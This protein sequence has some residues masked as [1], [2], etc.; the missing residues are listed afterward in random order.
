MGGRG[1]QVRG[2]F[3]LMIIFIMFLF[4]VFVF[5]PVQGQTGQT[6]VLCSHQLELICFP[7]T[8]SKLLS[9]WS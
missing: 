4:R 8:K 5:A 2:S 9:L 7:G 3:F 1:V 6:Q